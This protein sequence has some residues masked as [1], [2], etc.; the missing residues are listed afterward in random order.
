MSKAKHKRLIA[1]FQQFKKITRPEEGDPFN[2]I[3]IVKE[4]DRVS[5]FSTIGKALLNAEI[6]CEDMLQYFQNIEVGSHAIPKA[7]IDSVVKQIKDNYKLDTIPKCNVKLPDYKSVQTRLCRENQ[8]MDK[9][10]LLNIDAIN[11]LT[12]AFS[13]MIE[14]YNSI[15]WQ[16]PK[17]S[18]IMTLYFADPEGLMGFT[19]RG[20]V[21]VCKN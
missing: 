19:I 13:K 7:H 4:E 8:S 15:Y 16:H 2:Y 3:N 9:Q 20:D 21:V 14:S 17:D 1:I 5:I 12:Q 6:T 18:G 11:K 10:V